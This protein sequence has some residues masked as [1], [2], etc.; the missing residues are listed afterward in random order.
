MEHTVKSV[1]LDGESISVC[2]PSFYSKRFQDFMA[3][4]V[5]RKVPAGMFPAHD[6]STAS[7]NREDKGMDP[8]SAES[9]PEV[10]PVKPVA[11]AVHRRSTKN[12]RAA[13]KTSVHSMAS[14]SVVEITA[15]SGRHSGTA[16]SPTDVTVKFS[17]TT[18]GHNKAA[19]FPSKAP[20]L[21]LDTAGAAADLSFSSPKTA[22]A[23][24]VKSAWEL[25]S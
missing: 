19:F 23:T 22:S 12:S 8:L 10:S 6:A 7:L 20:D 24:A 1:V 13:A 11:T 5:F 25:L 2:H 9:S 15:V 18:G 17:S 14:T 4:K 21:I 3:D 16:I